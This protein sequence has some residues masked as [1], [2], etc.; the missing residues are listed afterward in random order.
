MYSKGKMRATDGMKWAKRETEKS[1]AR[2]REL[3]S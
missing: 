2:E 1:G 3:V